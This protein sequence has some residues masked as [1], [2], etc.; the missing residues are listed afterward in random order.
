MNAEYKKVFVS[1]FHEGQYRKL[2][3]HVVKPMN[4]ES[5]YFLFDYFGWA[6][7]NASRIQEA[8]RLFMSGEYI[9]V[10]D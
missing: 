7:D 1:M 3:L 6:I 8:A 9:E 2:V 4:K 10:K 5:L